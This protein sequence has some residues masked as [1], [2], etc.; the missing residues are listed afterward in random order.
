MNTLP[1]YF[2][3]SVNSTRFYTHKVFRYSQF[4]PKRICKKQ[5]TGTLCEY[6]NETKRYQTSY[7]NKGEI[8]CFDMDLY[9]KYSLYKD[10]L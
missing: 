5:G 7:I 8:N 3:G 2:F 10:F 9:N 4:I 6:E 1:F